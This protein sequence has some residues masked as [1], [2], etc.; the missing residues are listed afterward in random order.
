MRY[1]N[2]QCCYSQYFSHH[3]FVFLVMGTVCVRYQLSL[4]MMSWY[5]IDSSIFSTVTVCQLMTS[6]IR[7]AAE[8]MGRTA[9][10]RL[11]FI[12]S[13]CFIYNQWL[14]SVIHW[15]IFSFNCASCNVAEYKCHKSNERTEVLHTHTHTHTHTRG[16]FEKFEDSPYYSDSELC[17]GAVTVS[18]SKYL[19]W[20]AVHFLQRSIHFSQ[21]C[22]RPLEISCLGVSFAWL[23]KP[24]SRM[25]RVVNWILVVV[26]VVV[27][28]VY[29]VID[30]VRKRLDT[31][32]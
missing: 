4:L 1:V 27:V 26:V 13:E 19:P 22:C 2:T 3:F 10:S 15:N 31:P 24:R 8:P 7:L 28:V 20:Q 16:P 29:F 17:G 11:G 6:C 25:G 18:F 23:E 12:I 14:A 21:T 30:S 5:C 9:V 32:S